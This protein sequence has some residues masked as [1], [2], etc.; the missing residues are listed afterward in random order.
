MARIRLLAGDLGITAGSSLYTEELALRLADRGHSV[1][2]V[3]LR[4]TPKLREKCECVEIGRSPRR[5][6]RLIWRFAFHLDQAHCAARLRGTRLPEADVAIA[7]EHV[8]LRPHARVQ[9]NIRLLYVPLSLV[10]PIE[11]ESY[12]LR[13]GAG[14]LGRRFYAKLQRWALRNADATIRFTKMSC[15]ELDAYYGDQV[16]RRYVVNPIAVHIPEMV[17][18]RSPTPPIRLLSVGRVTESKNL[19][20]AV[21]ALANLREY[22]WQFD[23][24]GQGEGLVD[25]QRL[26]ESMKLTERIRCHGKQPDTGPWYRQ[27][28]LFLFTSKLD[29]CPLVVLE[30]MSYGVPVLGVRPDGI[31]YRSGIEELIDNGQSGFLAPADGFAAELERTFKNS[32]RLQQIGAEARKRVAG[33]HNW[34]AHLSGYEG[35]IQGMA[36]A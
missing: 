8:L 2:V 12:G 25:L 15:D 21:K 5:N 24:I 35:L 19:Q 18:P 6:A 10:A 34:D 11:I 36:A 33:R 7:L 17:E 30:A 26:I 31:I 23:I 16:A 28:D 29:N 13:Y 14:W 22:S 20:L 3:A 4:A 32:E 9:P 1:S 27:A